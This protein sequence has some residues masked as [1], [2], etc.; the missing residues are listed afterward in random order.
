MA[1]RYLL[2]AFIYFPYLMAQTLGNMGTVIPN[3]EQER[4]VKYQVFTSSHA[5]INSTWHKSHPETGSFHNWAVLTSE[6]WLSDGG[7]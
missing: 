1:I 5:N 2:C 7:S 3:L 6:K 4:E